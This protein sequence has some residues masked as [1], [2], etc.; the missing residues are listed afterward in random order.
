MYF[1]NTVVPVITLAH[2]PPP[3]KI[4]R[5]KNALQIKGFC[6][7]EKLM[8]ALFF[9]THL[10]FSVLK[11]RKYKPYFLNFNWLLVVR[12]ANCFG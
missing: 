11:P 4:T 9:L 1:V 8:I 12:L 2:P 3:P 10:T 5:R 6:K 7:N